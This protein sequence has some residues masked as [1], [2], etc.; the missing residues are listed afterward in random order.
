MEVFERTITKNGT[1]ATMK[2]T[3]TTVC[4]EPHVSGYVSLFSRDWDA[5]TAGRVADRLMAI[6]ESAIRVEM[7]TRPTIVSSGWDA[8][9]V[10]RLPEFDRP[11]LLKLWGK[12]AETAFGQPAT[13]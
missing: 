12:V 13:D 3:T 8:G 10:F 2:V 1:S 6:L 5:E 4:G 7:S 9:G 11:E